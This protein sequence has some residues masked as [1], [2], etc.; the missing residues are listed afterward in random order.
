[1]EEETGKRKKAG[2]ERGWGIARLPGNDAIHDRRVN[3]SSC[4]KVNFLVAGLVDRGESWPVMVG[5][6]GE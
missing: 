4:E 1:M 3:E 5:G 6:K 2:G